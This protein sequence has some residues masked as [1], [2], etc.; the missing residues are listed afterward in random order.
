MNSQLPQVTTRQ[1]TRTILSSVGGFSQSHRQHIR[2]LQ[3][4]LATIQRFN[5]DVFDSRTLQKDAHIGEGVSYRVSRC[6]H[7]RTNKLYARKEVKLP[8]KGA[9]TGA[10]ERQIACVL[11]DVEVM[12]CLAN[13]SNILDIFGYGWDI[14]SGSVIPFLVTEFAAEGTL[15]QFLRSSQLSVHEKLLFCK[16]VAQGLHS[17]HVAGIAHGDLKLD[18]VLVTP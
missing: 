18:N 6:L 1:I 16:D 4:L 15:R 5:L 12:Y 7:T 3:D 8:P 13:R 17:L 9:D 14:D 2:S 10:F 11:R